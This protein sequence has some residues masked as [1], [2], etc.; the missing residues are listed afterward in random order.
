MS[1]HALRFN[2]PFTMSWS[3]KGQQHTLLLTGVLKDEKVKKTNKKQL[4]IILIYL[5]TVWF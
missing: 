3:M 5:K 4:D 2:C 1:S